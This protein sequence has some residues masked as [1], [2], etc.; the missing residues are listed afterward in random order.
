MAVRRRQLFP[1]FDLPPL[2]LGGALLGGL[3]GGEAHAILDVAAQSG[4]IELVDTSS[5][6]GDS[7][8]VIGTSPA[9][10]SVAT[11]FGNPCGL[12]NHTHDYSAAH[13]VTALY[14]SLEQLR[15]KP[16]ACLQLHSPPEHPTPLVPALVDLLNSMRQARKIGAWGASVH[17]VSGG[18]VA[19]SAGAQMLQV[20]YNLLQ[21]DTAAL[22]ATCAIQGV[23]V[24][25][26]SSLCQGWLTEQGVMAARLL[27]SSPDRLPQRMCVHGGE[28]CFPALLR[29]VLELD[30]L[31]LRF[32]T[33]LTAMALR[34]ALHAPGATSVLVQARTASQLAQVR[35]CH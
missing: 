26:Q 19:L 10:L 12:N 31:A 28:V 20:P 14:N 15:G 21:Q 7:E 8:A 22:L 5:A 33:T 24:L 16:I 4:L 29:R 6:Y 13:C 25:V 2:T 35:D 30:A 1:G 27:L 17:S 3:D 23:G 11:K 9:Q 34:F 18:M 32:G